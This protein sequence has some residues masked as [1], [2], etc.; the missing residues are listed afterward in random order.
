[1][2]DSSRVLQDD[3]VDPSTPTLASCADTPFSA[4]DLESAH[5]F[6]EG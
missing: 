2:V 3:E 4:C 5:I 1:V 6:K